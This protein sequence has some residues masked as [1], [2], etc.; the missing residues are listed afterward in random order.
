LPLAFITLGIVIPFDG[1]YEKVRF[2]TTSRKISELQVDIK[3]LKEAYRRKLEDTT[4]ETIVTQEELA[5]Q[6]DIGRQ[7][8]ELIVSQ[9]LEIATLRDGIAL[10]KSKIH[11]IET[12]K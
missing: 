1:L 6:L 11:K 12:K 9:S 3:F 5:A 7:K 4:L 2:S 8:D 10:L